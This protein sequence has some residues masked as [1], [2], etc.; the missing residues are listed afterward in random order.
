MSIAI[1]IGQIVQGI[2]GSTIHSIAGVLRM[3]TEVPPTA[4]AA[5]LAE[6][7]YRTGRLTLGAS[8][9]SEEIDSKRELVIGWTAIGRNKPLVASVWILEDASRVAAASERA[10]IATPVVAQ[11]AVEVEIEPGTEVFPMP[12]A[13]E[14]PAPLAG[15]VAPVEA[16]HAAAA[17]AVPPAC[18]AARAAD[19][20]VDRGAAEAAG[21]AVADSCSQS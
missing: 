20:G 19:Q 9:V 13:L 12:V 2:R 21:D 1:P 3:G 11:I 17:L 18:A 4:S 6:T 5:Q 14:I 7:R 8:R 15:A 10:V 16:A